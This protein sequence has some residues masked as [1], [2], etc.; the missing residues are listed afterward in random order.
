MFLVP[1]DTRRE[2]Y[3]FHHLFRELLRFR[4]RAEDPAEES[5][6]LR[7]A[8]SWHLERSQVSPAV[9]YLLRARD[10]DGVLDV[11]MTR[12]SEVFERGEMA[13][14]IR[15]INEVPEPVRAP[16][17]DVNLLLGALK[18]A[19]GQAGGAEDILQR[20]AAAGDATAGERAAAQTLL[21]LL[22]QWRPRPDVSLEMAERALQ[23]LARLGENPLPAIMN[24]TDRQFT[25]DGRHHLRRPRPLPGRP[26][27]R[28]PALDRPRAGNAG[29]GVLDLARERARLP[30]PGGGLGGTDR[31]G[32][33]VDRGGSHH[34]ARVGLISH[35]SNADAYLSATLVALERGEPRRAALSLHEG[36]L[37]SEANRRT[38]LSWVSTLLQASLEA[39]DGQQRPGCRHHV[40]RPGTLGAPPPPWWPTGWWPWVRLL[41]LDGSSRQAVGALE[42]EDLDSAPVA[43]EA[44]PVH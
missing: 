22:A 33:G 1:L 27:G 31:T 35:P 18:V 12:G 17:Q 23:L 44:R 14:V 37:R 34:L 24:L 42:G 4:L 43:F 32:R 26:S 40:D 6:L 9:D 30:G 20:V 11:I 38:Q 25:G 10:W 16:R 5:R 28:G 21:S 39:A 8:A 15:W 3:R 2:W 19:E 29:C 13:T 7:Q 41:R 36:R